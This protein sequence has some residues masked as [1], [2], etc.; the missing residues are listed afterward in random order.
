M[1]LR[2][3]LHEAGLRSQEINVFLAC[4]EGFPRVS[5]IIKNV[6]LT[7]TNVYAILSSLVKKG[8]VVELTQGKVKEFRAVSV[9]RLYDYI[10][11]QKMTL[12]NGS[13]K[14][15]DVLDQI[16]QQF[17]I[18]RHANVEF[19]NGIK[20]VSK[21]YLDMIKDAGQKEFK[22]ITN[23]MRYAAV[24]KLIDQT[25]DMIEKQYS[26]LKT[27]YIPGKIIVPDNDNSRSIIA[28]Q[29][30]KHSFY[31]KYNEHRLVDFNKVSL[32]SH[33][34]LTGNSASLLSVTDR[35]TWAVRFFDNSITSTF[36]AVFSALWAQGKPYKK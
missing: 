30:S 6:K 16:N 24:G 2:Y 8:L 1:N 28:Y 11:Q 17:A 7:R 20:E 4:T 12:Q 10:E 13:K 26:K 23:F 33:L 29:A 15:D 27:N 32:G 18:G 35:E 3:F 36:E 19:F 31:N 21:F 25:N 14:L 34:V 5:E 22:E 9:S